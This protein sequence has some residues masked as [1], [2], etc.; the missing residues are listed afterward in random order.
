MD[1]K[2][3]REKCCINT[4]TTFFEFTNPAQNRAKPSKVINKTKTVDV[5]IQAVSPP[6]ILAKAGNEIMVNNKVEI[7]LKIIELILLLKNSYYPLFKKP[8]Q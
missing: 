5:K 1:T 2:Q 4:D 3:A 8:N 7:T 6:L